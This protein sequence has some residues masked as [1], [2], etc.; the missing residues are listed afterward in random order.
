VTDL[1]GYIEEAERLG[2]TFR[3]EGDQVKVEYPEEVRESVWPILEKLR[4]K[5][6]E[7]RQLLYKHPPGV[8]APAG[9]PPLPPG[10]RLVRYAP[11]TPPVA[12][13][14]CS[15]VTDVDKFI[16]AYL[17]D[18]DWRLKNPKG[19]AAAPLPEILSKLAEVG[20][21]LELE[22][23]VPAASRGRERGG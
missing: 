22:A 12:V 2:C 16:A 1:E 18:L 4:P 11:K 19:Y 17:Q 21:E 7:V 10:V 8:P 20:L 6:D 3:L 14:P 15:I 13:Q 9:C 23:P 5:R